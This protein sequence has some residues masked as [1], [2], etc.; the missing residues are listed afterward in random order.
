MDGPLG[1]VFLDRL[2]L[3]RS[4]MDPKAEGEGPGGG[5]EGGE[6]GGRRGVSGPG[7]MLCHVDMLVF[8]VNVHT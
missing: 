2:R 3:E 1:D 7:C 5:G 4:P 6:E 8:G